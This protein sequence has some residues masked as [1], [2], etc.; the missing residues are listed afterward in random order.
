M[1]GPIV[2]KYVWEESVYNEGTYCM[3]VMC[4]KKA[5][6]MKEP[7]VCKLCIGKK[8]FIT[9]G[10]IVCKLCIGKKAFITKGPVVCK[11]CVVKK[12]L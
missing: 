1:K 12:L 10:P 11:L 5:F 3:Q 2:C 8:A 6:I 7:I 9:K 4:G